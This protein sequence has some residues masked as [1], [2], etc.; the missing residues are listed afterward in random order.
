MFIFDF[1]FENKKINSFKILVENI[2][3]NKII[4]N[5]L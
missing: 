4:E 3:E 5:Y 2:L 1:I